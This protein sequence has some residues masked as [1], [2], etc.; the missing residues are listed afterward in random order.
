MEVN[1]TDEQ[2]VVGRNV[3]TRIMVNGQIVKVTGW[4]PN[5]IKENE[6]SMRL[7]ERYCRSGE[8]LVGKKL[9]DE[10]EDYEEKELWGEE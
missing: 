1:N 6:A 10:L 9:L 5:F 7:R 3:E 2:Q 8:P 4:F